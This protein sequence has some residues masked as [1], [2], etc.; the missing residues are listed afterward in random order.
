MNRKLKVKIYKPAK[1]AM[2]S[3]LKNKYWLLQP[4]EEVN[5]KSIDKITGWTSS[6]NTTTQINLRFL[7]KEDAIKYA[8]SQGFEYKIQ[9]P[10]YSTVKKKSYC[11]NFQN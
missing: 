6:N 5:S 2:Q 7:N 10:Q 1:N 4:I 8:V 11:D 9:E 3:G